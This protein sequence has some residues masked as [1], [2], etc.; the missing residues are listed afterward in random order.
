MKIEFIDYPQYSKFFLKSSGT[1]K[2]ILEFIWL[3]Q[4]GFAF[5]YNDISLIIDPYLSDYLSKKY[6]NGIFPHIRLTEIPILP[7]NIHNLDVLL[8]THPHSDH[9]DPETI[10]Q[11]VKSNPQLR[12]IV[13]AP[14]IEEAMKRGAPKNNII[15]AYSENPI[16]I[17]DDIEIIPIPAAHEEIKKDELGNHFYL[18]YIFKFGQLTVYHSGDCIPYTELL[19]LIRKYEV[20]I[21]FLPINGRDEYR[22]LNNIAGNFQIPEVLHLCKIAPISQLIVHHFGMF[23]YNTV[24]KDQLEYIKSQSSS[25]LDI[26]IPKVYRKYT[27]RNT[28]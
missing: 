2:D 14:T 26:T 5:R 18:G 11:L 10:P 16:I 1:L 22:S 6:K 20:E 24:T 27:I 4:A 19:N 9:M 23:E 7:E 17:T 13:P 15:L 25:N 3:G 8:S 21:A 28:S 12:I